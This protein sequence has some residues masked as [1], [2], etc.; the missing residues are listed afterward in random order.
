MMS[1]TNAHFDFESSSSQPKKLLSCRAQF[2][3][4]VAEVAKWEINDSNRGGLFEI[5][6]AYF[7]LT[8]WMALFKG[9][10]WEDGHY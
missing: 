4:D 1:S 8:F 10:I 9:L 2:H 6:C 5:A 7:S 3:L